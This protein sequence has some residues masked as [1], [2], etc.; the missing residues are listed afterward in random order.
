MFESYTTNLHKEIASATIS[1]SF[2]NAKGSQLSKNISEL[3]E[4]ERNI[5]DPLMDLIINKKIN[6]SVNN[7]KKEITH[8]ESKKQ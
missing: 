3:I 5:H 8:L 2:T 4:N 6:E 1:A 7:A